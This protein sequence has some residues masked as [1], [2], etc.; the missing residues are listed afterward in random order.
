[1]TPEQLVI[2]AIN[3]ALTLLAQFMG[4]RVREPVAVRFLTA[5]AIQESG[6]TARRQ[7]GNGPAKSFWQ[8]EPIGIDGVLSHHGSRNEAS[9]LCEIL[10]YRITENEP[11]NVKQITGAI[12]HCDV[13]AA[14]FARLNLW[15][16]PHSI[17]TTEAEGWRIYTDVWGPGKP[18]RA[19]WASAWSRSMPAL[20]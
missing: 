11:E 19:R 2:T 10:C 6:L 12:E 18:D 15:K 13:L 3:P 7:A 4:E 20:V 14:G 16:T 17:P 9:R 5:I 8:F 1:M